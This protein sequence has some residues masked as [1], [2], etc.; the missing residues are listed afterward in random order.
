M[1]HYT[2]VYEVG[3]VVAVRTPAIDPFKKNK[4]TVTGLEGTVEAYAPS[5]DPQNAPAD[6]GNPDSS[7]A[8]EYVDGVGYVAYLD[9]TGFA[10]A[11][12]WTIRVHLFDASGGYGNVE[13]ATFELKL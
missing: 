2:P 7:V 9:T 11:G 10:E 12:I 8:F 1:S 4:T 3:E 6:R 5:K 13:Y